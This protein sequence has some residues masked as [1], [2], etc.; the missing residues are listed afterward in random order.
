M[1]T[2]TTQ[3][4]LA[5]GVGRTDRTIREWMAR[6]DW[7]FPRAGPFNVEAVRK[8]AIEQGLYDR[9]G[10]DPAG[11]ADGTLKV[12]DKTDQLRTQAKLQKL[13]ADAGIS[14]EKH[15]RYK[16]INRRDNR[17]LLPSE[18]LHGVLMDAAAIWRETTVR[19]RQRAE[20][21]PA[22]AGDA[23]DQMLDHLIPM[24]RE[25]LGIEKETDD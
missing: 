1:T 3:K 9:L 13:V 17:E 24:L 18:V 12:S 8:W 22:E 5:K 6:P 25:R 23:I 10:S 19:I 15:K 2:V 20:I 16:T 14:A 11:V 21:T 7:S 4:Q